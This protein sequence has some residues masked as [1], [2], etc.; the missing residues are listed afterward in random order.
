MV[1]MRIEFNPR[2]SP[3]VSVNHNLRIRI[4][5]TDHLGS[6]AHV[7]ENVYHS[8]EPRTGERTRIQGDTEVQSMPCTNISLLRGPRDAVHRPC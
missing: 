6:F 1:W 5:T 7:C 3:S 2:I 8:N 4:R